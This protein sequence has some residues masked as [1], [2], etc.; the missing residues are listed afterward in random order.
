LDKSITGKLT[1]TINFM[2]ITNICLIVMYN[3]LYT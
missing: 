2:K 1:H 3:T